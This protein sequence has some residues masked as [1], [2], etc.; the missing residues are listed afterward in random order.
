MEQDFKKRIEDL[1]DSSTLKNRLSSTRFLDPAEASAARAYLRS[2][3]DVRYLFSGGYEEAERL[4]LFFLPDYLNEEFFPLDEHIAALHVKCP[5]GSPTHRDW[6]G[7][8]MGLGIKRETLG[9][10]LVFDGYTYIICTPQISGFISDNLTKVGR[11]G[12]KCEPCPLSDVKAPEPVF[13][14][15]SGTVASLR[16]DAVVSLAFGISRTAAAEL[17]RDGRLSVDHI[18]E[19]SPSR[20]I[21]QGALLS[22]RGAGR[23]KLADIGGTSKKGRQFIELHVFSKK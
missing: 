6:L 13:D 20:E 8:L 1:A 10:I 15:V 18:E 12:V 16:A 11:F 7:A 21:A 19:T 14:A 17:I 5:F 2:R 22:L 4:R 9:D 3:P 23:A